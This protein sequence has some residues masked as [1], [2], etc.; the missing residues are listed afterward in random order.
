MLAG[1]SAETGILGNFGLLFARGPHHKGRDKHD[2]SGGDDFEVVSPHLQTLIVE[3]GQAQAKTPVEVLGGS[4]PPDGSHNLGG[5]VAGKGPALIYQ[6][7]PHALALLLLEL[8]L[9]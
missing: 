7:G 2:S 8:V 4:P 3:I 1:G 9:L 6:L 5:F